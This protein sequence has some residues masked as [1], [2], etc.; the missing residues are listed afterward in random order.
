MI[1]WIHIGTNT[2]KEL[3][4]AKSK[5]F[6]HNYINQLLKV[7]EEVKGKPGIHV[8]SVTHDNWCNFM[9]DNKNKC[10]SLGFGVFYF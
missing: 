8:I 1:G 6:K 5:Y 9:K 2:R 3:E 7:S 4:M 10:N